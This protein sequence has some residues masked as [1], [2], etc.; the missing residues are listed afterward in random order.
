[1]ISKRNKR[2]GY[3]FTAVQ[4]WLND[5]NGLIYHNGCYHLFYQHFP[6]APHWGQMHWGHATSSDML[7]WEHQPTALFPDHPYD[8][9][10]DGGCFSGSA[11]TSED[12]SL[13]LFYTGVY[14][15]AEN[16]NVQCQCAASSQDGLYF[17]KH[18]SNPLIDGMPL[19]GSRDF[20][21]PK[22]FRYKNIWYMVVGTTKD[23]LG[24]VLLYQS[25]DK[26][27]WSF[28]SVLFES[29][30]EFG[31]MCECPDFFPVQ[32]RWILVFSPI[33]VRFRKSVYLVGEM[34]WD[35]GKFYPVGQGE[36]DWGF[37]FYAPQTFADTAGNRVMLSWQ[38]A[39]D[40]MPWYTPEYRRED[41]DWCGF[42]SIPRV[43]T[44][45]RRSLLSFCPIPELEALRTELYP[46][47][48]DK[49]NA[50]TVDLAEDYAEVELKALGTA[51][52]TIKLHCGGQ[53]S[54]F[55]KIDGKEGV[56]TVSRYTASGTY[57]RSFLLPPEPE[58]TARLFLDTHS[59]ELF[60]QDG[61]S[62]FSS[63]LFVID[64]SRSLEVSSNNQLRVLRCWQLR[65]S[66]PT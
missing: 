4:N 54:F 18:P 17:E 6:S 58:I 42:L 55:V 57:S 34:D 50:T 10:P 26:V 33:G 19:H 66:L 38:Y 64:G 25:T 11:V 35:S 59:A 60:L 29:N 45:N 2:Q 14:R 44:L 40:S 61:Q 53:E 5:P 43:V 48:Y 1:M 36:C 8:N 31:R 7:H 32:N 30:G 24:R 13:W 41:C 9:S 51:I 16:Q 12:G 23:Q 3:H 62:V 20:R 63:E 65:P 47:H 27:N 15:D 49:A 21:D 37:D 52:V 28:R 56:A 46:L 22:V 39:W